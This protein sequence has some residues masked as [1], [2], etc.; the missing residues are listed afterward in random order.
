MSEL[1]IGLTQMTAGSLL[2]RP[3]QKAEEAVAREPLPPPMVPGN[4]EKKASSCVMGVRVGGPHRN[5][6]GC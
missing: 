3:L 1:L 6:N 2:T 5:G 4:Y